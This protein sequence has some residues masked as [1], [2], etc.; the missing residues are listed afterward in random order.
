M[1]TVTLTTDEL[2]A[3]VAEA[4]APL[5]SRIERLA[6][7]LNSKLATPAETLTTEQA[8]ERAKVCGKTVRK[9]VALGYLSDRRAG[10]GKGAH[11]ILADELDVMIAD[12]PDAARRFRDR[13]GRG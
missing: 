6:V 1:A 7:V 12:G 4:V 9:W 11:L 10:L 2:R 8:A 3:I 5:E 13:M